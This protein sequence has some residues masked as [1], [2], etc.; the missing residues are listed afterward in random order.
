[1][2]LFSIKYPKTTKIDEVGLTMAKYV[3]VIN[4]QIVFQLV[5]WCHIDKKLPMVQHE[6]HH[7]NNAD[8]LQIANLSK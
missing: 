2:Y 4:M 1:L 3:S 8:Q 7:K 5:Q 6:I